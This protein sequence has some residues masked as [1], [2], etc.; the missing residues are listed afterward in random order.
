MTRMP[1]FSTPLRDRLAD[2]TTE[3]QPA[4]RSSRQRVIFRWLLVL[5]RSSPAREMLGFLGAESQA[6]RRDA[7]GRI[8]CY[9]GVAGV[10]GGVVFSLANK[11]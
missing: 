1:R 2:D 3:A 6:R 7:V 10:L 9:G 8:L 5:S 11:R 4:D